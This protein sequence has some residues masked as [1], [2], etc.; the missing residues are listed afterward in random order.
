MR[1]KQE[2]TLGVASLLIALTA[3]SA[4]SEREKDG[5]EAYRAHCASCH[6]TGSNDAPSIQNPKDWDGRSNLWEAVLFEHANKGYLTMPAKGGDPTV[7]EY[8]VDA[9]AEYMLKI[10]HPDFLP[11]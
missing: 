4:D 10:T 6:E 5:A 1:K 3:A 7:S 9:A 11:D 2:L 8:E